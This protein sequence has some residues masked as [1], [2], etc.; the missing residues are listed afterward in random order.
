MNYTTDMSFLNSSNTLLDIMSGVNTASGNLIGV[1]LMSL[2]YIGLLVAF[3]SKNY[4]FGQSMIITGF[5]SCVVSG[6]LFFMNLLAWWV[7]VIFIVL[8]IVGV[9]VESFR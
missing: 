9:L 2:V 7:A 1:G 5:I 6:L 4:D 8:L 3:L